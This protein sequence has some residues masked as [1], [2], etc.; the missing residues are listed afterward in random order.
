MGIE[1]LLQ[2]KR[3]EILRIA[4]K[5][6]VNNVRVFGSLARGEAG[7]ESD[8]DLLVEIGTKHTPFF[9][10]GLVAELENLLHRR[11]QVFTEQGIHWYIRDKVLQEAVPL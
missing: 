6:G 2:D 9:P 7:P 5:H 1:E 11:V 8:V 4:R 10:G 3:E